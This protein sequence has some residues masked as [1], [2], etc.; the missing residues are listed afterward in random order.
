MK[1]ADLHVIRS[2]SKTC[3]SGLYE[4]ERTLDVAEVFYEKPELIKAFWMDGFAALVTS[5]I[6]DNLYR[7]MLVFFCSLC[8]R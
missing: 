7:C 1:K 5:S 8:Y 6:R 3:M 4:R 2:F